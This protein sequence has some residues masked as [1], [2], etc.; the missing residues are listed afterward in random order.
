MKSHNFMLILIFVVVYFLSCIDTKVFVQKVEVEGPMLQPMTK[1]TNNKNVDEVETS[2]RLLVNTKDEVNTNVDGHTYVS[3]NGQYVVEEVQNENYY[4]ENIG[5]N[6]FQFKG[7]NTIWKLPQFQFGLNIDFPVSNNVSFTGGI[8]YS[9]INSSTYWNSNVGIGFFKELK[10][11]SWRFDAI[12]N[13]TYLNTSLDYV[14][15]KDYSGEDFKR[16][17]FYN[18]EVRDMY[19]DFKFMIT[20]NTKNLEFFADIFV[21]ASFG[22]QRFFNKILVANDSDGKINL[23]NSPLNFGF[24][25]YKNLTP[26]TRLI[27]GT[28]INNQTQ[29]NPAVAYPVYFLQLD[30]YLFSGD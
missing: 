25:F 1:I 16:V 24:G 27:I 15:T 17:Y 6:P 13:M 18:T 11:A 14:V 22:T 8:D 23:E 19:T 28:T 21:N 9:N 30:S 7:N 3:Y 10:N 26:G 4:R 5:D 12:Y 29:R 20:L 2:V